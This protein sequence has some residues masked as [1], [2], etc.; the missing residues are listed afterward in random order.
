MVRWIIDWRGDLGGAV[1][2]AAGFLSLIGAA[3]LWRVLG[4]PSPE[5]TRKLTHLGAGVGCIALPFLVHSPW[6]VLVLA[7]GMTTLFA[8]GARFGFLPALHRVDRRTRGSEY[9]PVAVFLLFLMARDRPAI[10]V[11]AVLVLAVA[12]AFAA[13]IGMRYG[14]LRY[15]VEDGAKS[16]EGSVTFLLIAFLAIHLPLLLMTDLDRAHAVLSALLIA[17]LVTMF[18]A[19]SLSGADNLFV[20]IAV[21]IGLDKI[22]S[23]PLAEAIYQNLSLA[24]IALVCALVARRARWFNTGA[25]LVLILYTFGAWALGSWLWALPM[26]M[27]LAASLAVGLRAGERARGSQKVRATAAAVLPPFLFLAA[28]N[29][30]DSSQGALFG[31]YLAA[32]AA[33]VGCWIR[34]HS[35]LFRARPSAPARP[36]A[37]AEPRS[38]A[39]RLA[40]LAVVALAAALTVALPAWV[41]DP[42]R[43]VAALLATCAAAAAAVVAESVWSWLLAR[44]EPVARWTARRFLASLAAGGLVLAL[45]A[46]GAVPPWHPERAAID[47]QRA[48]WEAIDG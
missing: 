27:A 36:G 13:I 17:A 16:V 33:A 7:A 11:S 45:Q 41:F 6:V 12:D 42:D 1:L 15:E 23:K 28:R 2:L 46:A 39:P 44:G 37:P 19:I 18:E 9:Y 26:L 4:S 10:Y 3:E 14:R 35:S 8:L 31:A 34:A 29:A 30:L 40:L 32:L 38:P 22:T 20:P 48:V 5:A 47:P 25:T 24:A 43:S 21:A